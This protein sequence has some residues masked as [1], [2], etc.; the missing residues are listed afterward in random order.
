MSF[1]PP[2]VENLQQTLLQEAHHLCEM[3]A[4]E[5]LWRAFVGLA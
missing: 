4:Q 2:A 3:T 1:T 5:L